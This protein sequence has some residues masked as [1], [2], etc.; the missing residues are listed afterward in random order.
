MTLSPL[1]GFFSG[2]TDYHLCQFFSN[3]LRYSALNFLLSHPYSNFAMYLLGNSTLLSSAFLSSTCLLTSAPILPSKSS[4]KFFAF[5]KSSSFSQV[6]LSAVNPFHRTR[7]F[8]TPF[9]FL[10][11]RIFSTSHSSTPSTSTGFPSFFFC[12]FTCSLY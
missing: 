1:Q 4:T 2:E 7:Y 8:S 10:L 5:L 3:F 9:I 11:F 6:S 12:P